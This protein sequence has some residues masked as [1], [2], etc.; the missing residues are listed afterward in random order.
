MMFAV[1]IA[2]RQ[3]EQ[4]KSNAWG[5]ANAAKIIDAV[6]P[7]QLAGHFERRSVGLLA[8]QRA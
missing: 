7:V 5:S 1:R 8:L 4:P 2:K 3:R 6:T